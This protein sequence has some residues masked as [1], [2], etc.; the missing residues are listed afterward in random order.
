M[1]TEL[2]KIYGIE[3]INE[4]LYKIALTHPS[5]IQEKELPHTMCYERLEFLGDAVLKLTISEVL[6][7][8]FPNSTEGELS[9][10]RGIVVS[11]NTLAKI[12]KKLGLQNYIIFNKH[13]KNNI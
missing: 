8:M 10:I 13:E 2:A 12:S 6:Y 5:Y 9:K 4:N 1:K 7:K 11:D 3:P